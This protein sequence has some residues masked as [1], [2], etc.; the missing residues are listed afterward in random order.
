MPRLKSKQVFLKEVDDEEDG[1]LYGIAG[2]TYNIKNDIKLRLKG[3]R[4]NGKYEMWV[5]PGDML[6]RRHDIIKD[7][8]AIHERLAFE[9]TQRRSDAA[10]ESAM[11][12]RIIRD[13]R[14][15][16]E[17]NKAMYLDIIERFKQYH[18]EQDCPLFFPSDG[19]CGR[20]KR[21]IFRG[22]DPDEKLFLITSCPHCHKSYDD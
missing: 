13:D 3:T 12:R 19:F 14:V 21:N 20:C 8:N 17:E 18:V 1:V 16:Y 5:I 22:L 6:S 11:K 15:D 10:K 2:I 7:L 4:W 9:Q